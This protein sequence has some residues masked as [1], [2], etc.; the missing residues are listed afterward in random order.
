MENNPIKNSDF[1][2]VVTAF[3]FVG[4]LF[5]LSATSSPGPLELDKIITIES[6]A[7]LSETAENLKNG[8]IL[9]YEF[10]FEVLVIAMAGDDGVISGEYVFKSAESAF[11]VSRRIVHGNYGFEK[12]KITFPE[13][14]TVSQMADTISK[15]IPKFEKGEFTR[16]SQKEEGYL[17][18]DTYFF[19]INAKATEIVSVLKENFYK[20]TDPLENKIKLFGKTKSEIIIMASIIE[21]EAVTPE[22]RRIVSGILWKRLK[23]G[24][25]LQVDATFLYTL[26]KRSDELTETDLKT[27]T[28]YNTYTRRGLPIA[29]IGNPGL[30]AI[31]SAIEPKDSAYLFYLSDDNGKMHYAKNFD[32]HKIN[33][34]KYLR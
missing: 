25:P 21:K 19:P 26:G 7:T 6:G 32:G 17:F 29:P 34:A 15:A 22:D 16:L 11:K 30:D 2:V 13:G 23:L 8:G 3:I 18:P 5:L 12:V 33:K 24:I 9:K 14:G 27:D 1:L 10:P 20:K 4:I 28:P 31:L